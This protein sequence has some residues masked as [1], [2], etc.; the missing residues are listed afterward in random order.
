MHMKTAAQLRVAL[1]GKVYALSK[2]MGYDDA[3][4]RMVLMT[5]TGKTSC[6]DMTEKQLSQLADALEGL[7]KGNALPDAAQAPQ[8]SANGLGGQAL[9]TAKQWAM[10]AE[11]ACRMGWSG[12]DDA[13][14][15]TFAQRTA[16]VGAMGELSRTDMSKVISGL[17]R[18]L[19]QRRAASKTEGRS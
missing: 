8:A 17:T 13:S 18:W 14:L 9:P 2:R 16:R 11:L 3:T 4:Y 19:A 7:S 5:Q 12:L 15:L 1:I 6:R 10:L